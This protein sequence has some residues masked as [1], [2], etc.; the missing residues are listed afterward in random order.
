MIRC[1]KCVGSWF[2]FCLMY[3]ILGAKEASNTKTPTGTHTHT[4]K[5]STTSHLLR[6]LFKKGGEGVDEDVHCWWECKLCSCSWK[7]VWSFLEYGI[8]LWFSNSTLGICTQELKEETWTDICVPMF[9]AALFI[10]GKRWKRPKCHG[11]MDR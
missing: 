1:V 7:M 10:S 11:R 6:W 4:Q 8:T 5:T 3:P 2:S 9:T